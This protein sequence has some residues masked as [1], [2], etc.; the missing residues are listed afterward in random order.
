MKFIS[1]IFEEKSTVIN[2]M[3]KNL[4]IFCD[5]YWL[6][7]LNPYFRYEDE[8]DLFVKKIT[9]NF[10]FIDL[11]ANIGYWSLYFSQLKLA[12]QI[13]SIEPNPEC[14]RILEQ[15]VLINNLKNVVI[16][17]KAI[18]TESDSSEVNFYVPSKKGGHAGGSLLKFS[19]NSNMFKV[20]TI[21]VKDCLSLIDNPDLITLYKI[22]VEGF[23][24]EVLK[25][26]KAQDTN[27][28]KIIYEDH[29]RDLSHT[30]TAFLLDQ[31]YFVFFLS[32]SLQRIKSLDEL[33][34]LK[35]SRKVGYNL[36]AL[37]SKSLLELFS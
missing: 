37:K 33:S 14:Y 27:N 8:I 9:F 1:L 20:K 18:G 6:R 26:I 24:K 11:G 28:N 13:I 36:M 4:T 2:I 19:N 16:V 10:N 7:L 32:S 21:S 3:N 12:K 30:P 35:K 17:N 23:E 34:S 15:N 31:N 29:G 5:A 22:D 25:Q